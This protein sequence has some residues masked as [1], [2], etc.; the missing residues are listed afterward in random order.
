M[1]VVS[2][3]AGHEMGAGVAVGVEAELLVGK[4]RRAPKTS[5]WKMAVPV[6]LFK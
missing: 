4:S 2:L 1:N 6:T 5:A 3:L